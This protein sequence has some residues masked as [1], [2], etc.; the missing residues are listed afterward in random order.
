MQGVC[1]RLWGGAFKLEDQVQLVTDQ[2]IRS[3]LC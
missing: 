2:L 1:G 3:D